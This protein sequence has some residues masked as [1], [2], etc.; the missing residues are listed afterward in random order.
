MRRYLTEFV[1]TLFFVMTIALAVAV[2][3]PL[4]P[5]II[6]STLM[7][8]VYMGGP[9]SGGHYNPAVTLAAFL[10]NKMNRGDLLPY[11]GAQILGGLVGA[12]LA[13]AQTGR[14]GAKQLGALIDV[15][16][17]FG[18]PDVMVHDGQPQHFR[19][20]NTL[21][22]LGEFAQLFLRSLRQLVQVF[23]ST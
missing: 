12:F 22:K 4:T 2:N 5:L 15:I 10:R 17:T 9:V 11:W 8:V 23:A 20:R 14:R 18:L 13:E 7:V 3:N 21:E 1:G 19:V 16:D 6:G